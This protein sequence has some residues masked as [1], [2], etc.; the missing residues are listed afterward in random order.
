MGTVGPNENFAP[1]VNSYPHSQYHT[2]VVWLKTFCT[3]DRNN[4]KNKIILMPTLNN[5][6]GLW[7][8]VGL[9]ANEVPLA[10]LIKNVLKH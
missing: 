9:T 3:K 2:G 1:T 8:V 6:L 7:V 10:M 5:V 4:K